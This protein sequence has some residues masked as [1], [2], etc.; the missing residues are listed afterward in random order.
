[1]AD[2]R[3]IPS[4]R[5]GR[6]ALFGQAFGGGL[7]EGIEDVVSQIAQKKAEDIRAKDL[8]RFMPN[9]SLEDVQ[10]LARLGSTVY[11]PALRG[12]YGAQPQA[13]SNPE[14]MQNPQ[15]PQMNA[16]TPID[17]LK[18]FSSLGYNIP[19][20]LE[21][22]LAA[23]P[24]EQVAP[25]AQ[26]AFESLN[27]QQKQRLMQDLLAKQSLPQ[28]Q[29]PGQG[30]PL[31]QEQMQQQPQGIPTPQQ[32]SPISLA[33]ALQKQPL[34]GTTGAK[35]QAAENKRQDEFNY[36]IQ[37]TNEVD[38][39]LDEIE[40]V[41]ARNKYQTGFLTQKWIDA[42]LLHN[43]T[44][45][46]ARLANL[47]SRLLAKQQSAESQGQRGSNMLRQTIKEGKLSLAQPKS[48]L[49]DTF[50][51]I[52]RGNKAERTEI[53]AIRR[54]EQ[55]H[56]RPKRAEEQQPQLNAQEQREYDQLERIPENK[57]GAFL[58]NN[59]NKYLFIDD[60]TDNGQRYVRDKNNKWVEAK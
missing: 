33:Q 29:K 54:G 42:G 15:Q 19:P 41:L 59:P 58:R 37:F 60:F 50:N 10:A 22:R 40:K 32:Q 14:A 27:D 12:G 45:D 25:I 31:S 17:F 48:V 8:K 57:R 24:E 23:L 43:V 11:E 38:D 52:R 5:S 13:Q 6:A 44:P 16:P 35:G 47:F 3:W 49:K 1:M 53:E 28:Q 4:Q 21:K 2:T 18:S 34:N 56:E 9:A 30:L 51:D 20:E 46:T 39:I 36:E 7:G 26:K 55:L